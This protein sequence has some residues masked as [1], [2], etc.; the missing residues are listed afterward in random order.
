MST[1]PRAGIFITGTH[2]EVGKTYV[3]SLLARWFTRQG[4]RVGV[5]K[6]VASGCEMVDGQLVPQDGVELWEAAGR[7]GT[8]RDVCPQAFQAPLAPHLAARQA[9]QRV[10]GQ[11]L[12][13][14]LSVW[15][16]RCDL[17][18]VEGAG[19]L[20]SPISD[21][22]YVADLAAEFGYPLLIVAPNTLGVINQTLQTVITAQHHRPPLEVNG[23]I[24][25]DVRSPSTDLSCATNYSELVQ[26]LPIPVLAHVPLQGG[27][28]AVSH[29][30]WRLW[31][32]PSR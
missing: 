21:S 13:E 14:G 20:M 24:L 25:N 27:V 16:D 7:P 23:V 6:P 26:R 10:N 28:E 11:L 1:Y 9:G 32:T 29:L 18:L 3:T 4:C 15:T 19:G 12:R 31:A 22:D 30:D 17:V 8:L 5:Y 2:T